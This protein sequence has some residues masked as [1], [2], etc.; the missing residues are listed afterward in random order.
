MWTLA[1]K[2]LLHDRVKFAVA[3]AGVS[4]S[5][6]LVLVQIGLY[7]GFM[8]NASNL[9]DHSRADLWV[10]GEGSENFD[11]SAP[12]D[13]RIYYRVL[14]TP[15]VAAAERMILAFGQFRQAEGGTQGVQVVGLEKRPVLGGPWNVV[16]GD[17]GRTAEVDGIVVDQTEFGKLKIERLDERREISGARAKVVGLTKGIRSFTTSPFVFTNLDTARTYTRMEKDQIN[18][19]LVKAQPGVPLATIKARLDTIPHVAAYTTAEMSERTRAYWS[20]RTG[21]GAGFFT[22]AIMGIIVGLVVVGQILYNGTLEHVKEYGTL[23]AMGAKNRLVVGV[24]LLQAMIS[25]AVGFVVGGGLS[26]LSRAAM[27]GANLIVALSPQLL[28]ATAVLTACM[29]GAAALL[30]VLKVLRLDPATVF[31]G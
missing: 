6:L 21:V 24:I 5:V 15:G 4:I 27:R 10:T 31:K 9:I 25:A 3:S 17:T 23:K 30:S 2:I 22:T 29:C 1:R 14:E 11:F 16:A 20:S 28:A 7:F 13:E 8:Q 19:V 18:Y 26:F 12:L